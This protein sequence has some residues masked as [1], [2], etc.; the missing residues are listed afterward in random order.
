MSFHIG[1]MNVPGNKPKSWTRSE[2][3]IFLDL[4]FKLGWGG[5]FVTTVCAMGP[6]ASSGVWDKQRYWHRGARSG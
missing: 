3:P 5:G 6:F 1:D 4:A 2:D